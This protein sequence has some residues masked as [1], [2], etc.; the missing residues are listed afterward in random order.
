MENPVEIIIEELKRA[1]R[2]EADRIIQAMNPEPTPG[3]PGIAGYITLKKAADELGISSQTLWNHK[4]R[5]G[6][7][8]Q[9]GQIIFK[10]QDLLRYLDEGKPVEKKKEIMYTKYTRRK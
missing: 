4:T 7:T 3:Y 5:I 6:Y 10:R 1:L 8:K 2:E 9:F